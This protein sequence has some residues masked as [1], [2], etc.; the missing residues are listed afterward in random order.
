MITTRETYEL[1]KVLELLLQC[2]EL[3]PEAAAHVH[4]YMSYETLV[5]LQGAL[6]TDSPRPMEYILRGMRGGEP[7]TMYASTASEAIRLAREGQEKGYSVTID[8]IHY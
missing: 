5:L 8:E 1:K 3:F 4:Q 7:H 6:L 2:V